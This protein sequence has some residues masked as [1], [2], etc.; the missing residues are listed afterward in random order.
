MHIPGSSIRTGYLAVDSTDTRLAHPAKV[1]SIP[2]RPEAQS[3][4]RL[5]LLQSNHRPNRIIVPA[6][7]PVSHTQKSIHSSLL[8]SIFLLKSYCESRNFEQPTLQVEVPGIHRSGKSEARLFG[9]LFS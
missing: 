5:L 3:I 1:E 4:H 6:F 9:V 7:D 2:E 8:N